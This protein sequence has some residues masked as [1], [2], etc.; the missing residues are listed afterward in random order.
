MDR[1]PKHSVDKHKVWFWVVSASKELRERRFKPM[2]T[3]LSLLILTLQTRKTSSSEESPNTSIS[4][5]A[6]LASSQKFVLLTN[7]LA[8]VKAFSARSHSD[9]NSLQ[10][11]QH[12][13]TKCSQSSFALNSTSWF[14]DF[15]VVSRVV[16][17]IWILPLS[18]HLWERANAQNYSYHCWI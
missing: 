15:K 3:S 13:I 12:F 10:S 14:W 18:L 17:F 5:E 1:S 11:S 2:Q 4:W 16:G 6:E 9:S 8:N 7:C